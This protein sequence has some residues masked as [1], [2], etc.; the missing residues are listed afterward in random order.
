MSLTFFCVS[1]ISFKSK[2]KKT[3]KNHHHENRKFIHHKSEFNPTKPDNG[4]VIWWPI[5]CPKREAYVYNRM[6]WWMK[7][8]DNRL[9]NLLPTIQVSCACIRRSRSQ[10]DDDIALKISSWSGWA[11]KRS[12][13]IMMTLRKETIAIEGS[14]NL[15]CFYKCIS[16]KR[17]VLSFIKQANHLYNS[18]SIR[19][20][21]KTIFLWSLTSQ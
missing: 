17:A 16:N 5:I 21:K 8:P 20:P 7:S 4:L 9:K 2:V 18:T 3:K 19:W 6:K 1:E 11:A 12:N 13:W 10:L 14:A 15:I